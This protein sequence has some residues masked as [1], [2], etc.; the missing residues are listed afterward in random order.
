MAAEIG[1]SEG[2][3]QK[4]KKMN[5]H[6]AQQPQASG[7]GFTLEDIWV[8]FG[9][10][11]ALNGVT[12]HVEPHEVVGLMG[13][14][15][16][17]KS[18]LLNVAT[19]VVRPSRGVI[20]IGGKP[21]TGSYTPRNLS[22]L[23]VTIIHQE[24]ALAL[25]LSVFDNLF[26]GKHSQSPRPAKVAR[27][28]EILQNMGVRVD[29]NT[30]VGSL[31]MGERQLVDLCRGMLG[32]A[33]KVLLLDEPTAALGHEDS[34]RLHEKVRHFAQEGIPVVYVS[35]RLPD[36]LGVCSRIVVLQ[37][38]RTV[39]D[40]PRA[41]YTAKSLSTALAPDLHRRPFERV[42]VSRRA[43]MFVRFNDSNLEFSP[44]EAVGLFG[45]A[46]GPQFPILDALAGNGGGKIEATI[47]GAPYAPRSPFEARDKSVHLVPADREKDGIVANLSAVDNVFLPW[48]R[49]MSK[50][51]AIDKKRVYRTYE[52][53]RKQF[54]IIGPSGDAAITS[55]SGG[56][57]QKHLLA[58][59]M[60][61][62]TPKILLLAQP[63]QGVDEAA[64]ADIRK[65]IDT[66]LEE[67]VCILIASAESDEISS[68]CDR[69]YVFNKDEVSEFNR[70]ADLELQML[71]ALLTAGR[72]EDL[73]L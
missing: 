23:G 2:P 55:F 9:A 5:H 69:V 31:T 72:T 60:S 34:V 49:Q 22:E 35:H 29:L 40:Q 7:S 10:T 63:T 41:G 65:A 15:G 66:L 12:L 51:G 53:I 58:R 26:L 27:A 42:S 57:R 1:A 11:K 19:G 17:G 21:V 32:D 67:G 44:G 64:K 39:L 71:D 18:T 56:N 62:E 54:N 4:A 16:A 70:N 30:P 47:D 6:T 68:I 52:E 43:R 24:P 48:L 46:A 25:N 73:Q 13:H 14:N 59:W 8:N 38:G 36:I 37:E 28:R 50:P 61:V 45:V 3:E 33:P 20:K